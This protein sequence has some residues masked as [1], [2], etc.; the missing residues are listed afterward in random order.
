MSQHRP[1]L[2]PSLLSSDFS[3]LEAELSALEK[4]G[5][6]WVHWDVM[7]GQFVPN[8]TL[9][10]PII[11]ACRPRS[12]LFF[13][14]HLMVQGPERFLDDFLQAG[15]DL[16]SIHAEAC[17]HLEAAIAKIKANGKVAGLALN[18]HTPL[19]VLDYLL[20]TLDLVLIMSV[21]PGFGGQ[22][23]IPLCLQKIVDLRKKIKKAGTKTLIQVD[24]GVNL[25]NKDQIIAAGA[26]VLVS[27]S[28]FF[29]FKPYSQAVATFLN[30]N[31]SALAG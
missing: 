14:V 21:N 6:Q 23:F 29:E 30:Q 19:Q 17:L 31:P 10:A 25:E 18:P 28:A 24:G 20:P 26:D 13:D 2:S 3:R 1:I 11:K 5:L 16:I 22:Q 15:A 8:I 4:S 7:D 9:G 12:N 27:G